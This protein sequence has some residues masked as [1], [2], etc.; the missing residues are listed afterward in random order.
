MKKEKAIKYLKN[1]LEKRTFWKQVY[2][3]NEKD[4]SDLIDL[5]LNYLGC[6]IREKRRKEAIQEIKEA[7]EQI[8]KYQ[9]IVL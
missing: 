2:V 1:A 5:K 9:R 8:A 3:E 4:K 7:N 6:T